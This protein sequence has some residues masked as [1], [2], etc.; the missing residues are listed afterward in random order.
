L[1]HHYISDREA[2]AMRVVIAPEK[3]VLRGFVQTP[4][5]FMQSGLLDAA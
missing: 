1:L 4:E 3:A 2:R 5:G